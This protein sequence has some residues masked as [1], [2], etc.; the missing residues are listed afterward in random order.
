MGSYVPLMNESM[1]EMIYDMIILNCEYE[2]I[3]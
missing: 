1:K 2:I 3:Q